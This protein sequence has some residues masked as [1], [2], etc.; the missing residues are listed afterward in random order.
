MASSL[1]PP[2]KLRKKLILFGSI[3]ALIVSPFV[4]ATWFLWSPFGPSE[5]YTIAETEIADQGSLTLRAQHDG[6]ISD[7]L[8]ARIGDSEWLYVG[9][10]IDHQPKGSAFHSKDGRFH[11]LASDETYHPRSFWELEE[12]P[13]VVL[14][15]SQTNLIWPSE[16]AE[17]K[18]LTFWMKAWAEIHEANPDF[19]EPP[20]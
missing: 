7:N 11:G 19:P 20:A 13:T 9:Y 14:F 15:D 17:V 3:G 16:K 5:P 10:S 18:R 1:G 12:I 2:L 4:I 8:S 6:D